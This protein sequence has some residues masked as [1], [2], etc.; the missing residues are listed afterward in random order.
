MLQAARILQLLSEHS[1]LRHVMKAPQQVRKDPAFNSHY[2][3]LV[4]ALV[5]TR[6]KLSSKPSLTPSALSA[7]SLLPPAKPKRIRR[8]ATEVSLKAS[9]VSGRSQGSGNHECTLS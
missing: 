4:K 8:A 1:I 6:K 3:L 7:G 2:C 9:R 5:P